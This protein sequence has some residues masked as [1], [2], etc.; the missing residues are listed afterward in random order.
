MHSGKLSA[1]RYKKTAGAPRWIPRL[2][3][4][5][6]WGVGGGLGIAVIYCVWVTIVYLVFGDDPFTRQGVTLLRVIETCLAAGLSAGAVIGLLRPVAE[7]EFGAFGVGLNAGVPI[8]AG[9]VICVEGWPSTWSRSVRHLFPVFTLLVGT[10]VGSYLNKAA[11]DRRK[12][13]DE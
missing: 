11:E 12:A 7:N 13:S 4:N 1:R 6:R 8:S 9:L 10:A 3:R 2:I 5:M